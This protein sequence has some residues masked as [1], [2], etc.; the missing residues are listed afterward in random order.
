M[1]KLPNILTIFRLLLIFPINYLLFIHKKEVALSLIFLAWIT[2][3]LDGYLARKMNSVT[4]LGKILDPLADKLLIF[5][6]VLSLVSTSVLPLWVGIVV[7]SRD[8]L[9]LLAGFFAINKHNYVTQ[10]NWV[11]KVSA[12]LIGGILVIILVF[13]KLAFQ[14]FLHFCLI[15]IIILSLVLY[16]FY[17]YQT[18]KG[19][20]G[21]NI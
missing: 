4:N 17:Y 15:L 6:I 13:E 9:I 3:L 16:S 19:L 21:K 8:L 14:S 7:I 11:G 2:D 18:I 10:S 20:K 5:S 12:F 1:N